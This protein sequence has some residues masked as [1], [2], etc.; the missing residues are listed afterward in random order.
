LQDRFAATL[1]DAFSLLGHSSVE[2]DYES[3]LNSRPDF[4]ATPWKAWFGGTIA[5][6]GFDLYRLR[7]E[8][9][10]PTNMVSGA[11]GGTCATLPITKEPD[12]SHKWLMEL[13]KTRLADGRNLLHVAPEICLACMQV[14]DV[15]SLGR[16]IRAFTDP[17]DPPAIDPVQAALAGHQLSRGDLVASEK[18]VFAIHS[19]VLRDPILAKLVTALAEVDPDQ[20]S[21]HLLLIETAS[22][23]VELAGRLAAKPS[24][25]DAVLHRLVVATGNSAEALAEIVTTIPNLGRN[26][27]LT[28]LSHKLQPDRKTTLRK[29]AELHSREAERCLAEASQC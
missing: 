1:G 5:Q 12:W 3:F 2:S 23:R 16:W 14:G 25:S 24:L 8:R 26:E 21:T 10:A 7:V 4:S 29:L 18:H 13:E 20:A 15:D 27:F 17:S 22:L 28:T 11:I 6:S 9:T 19:A